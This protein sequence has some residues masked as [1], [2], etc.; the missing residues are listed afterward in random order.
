MVIPSSSSLVAGVDGCPSGWICLAKDQ[1][2]G[3]ICAA[4]YPDAATLIGE[5]SQAGLL[6]VDI[7]IGLPDAG[8]RLC[9]R[10]ARRLLGWPCRNSVF[11]APIRPAIAA[12]S[13]NSACQITTQA[14]GRRVSKQTWSIIPKIREIDQA[15]RVDPAAQ[16]QL[17]EVHP[18]ICFWAWNQ[19]RAMPHKKKSRDGR[20]ER[21]ALIDAHF[22]PLAVCQVRQRFRA[23]DVA[24]DDIYDAFAALWTAERINAGQASVI[25]EQPDIDSAGL[26]MGIWY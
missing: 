4:T 26:R 19:R 21:R 3:Q 22:G 10:E 13:W 15:L 14:D 17:C 18:E 16:A 20:T 9:D 7:P 5:N 24:D 1:S 12:S 11:P 8:E 2:T 25:P 6:A 23:R